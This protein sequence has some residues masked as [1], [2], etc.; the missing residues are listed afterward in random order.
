MQKI[1]EKVGQISIAA[2]AGMARRGEGPFRQGNSLAE[3]QKSADVKHN[4]ALPP[5][6]AKHE[7]WRKGVWRPRKMQIFDMFGGHL[8]EGVMKNSGPDREMLL[9][10]AT[11]D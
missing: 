9:T 4:L 2:L 6:S 3:G 10:V 8:A 7:L 1:L 11:W 5:P